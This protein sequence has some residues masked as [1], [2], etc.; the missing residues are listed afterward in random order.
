M[1]A[2]WRERGVTP[3]ETRLLE[4]LAQ[5]EATLKE[6]REHLDKGQQPAGAASASAA[7]AFADE[8]FRD[9]DA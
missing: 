4:L 8:A 5:L 2:A 7:D 9:R 1:A 3:Y 6:V